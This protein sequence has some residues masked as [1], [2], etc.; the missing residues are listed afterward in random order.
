[1]A[2]AIKGRGLRK[3]LTH[4][5]SGALTLAFCA[6]AAVLVVVGSQGL[7]NRAAAAPEPEAAPVP[8]VAVQRVVEQDSFTVT[9][10]FLGQVEAQSEVDV[11][12]EFGGTL[13]RLL[14][15]EGD[16][17]TQGDVIAELDTELLVADQSRLEAER[18]ALQAQL[19][20]AES[21][22]QRAV[23]LAEDGFASQ[24]RVDQA[25]ASQ[26]E[27]A[28]RIDALDA[29]LLSI[30]ISLRKSVITAPVTGQVTARFVD[31]GSVLSA[32]QPV[33]GLT[34][35]GPAIVRVG[36]PLSLDPSDLDAPEI[37]IDGEH[38]RAT[39]IGT[40]PDIDPVTRTRTAL[41]ALQADIPAVFGQTIALS[42][43]IPQST[44]GLWLPLSALRAGEQGVW[45]VL[46]VQDD[47]V[48]VASVEVLHTS[49]ERAYVRGS[50]GAE[51]LLVADGAH[52]LVPGQQ[53]QPIL[54]EG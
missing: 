24:E 23:R 50:F 27:L 6:G 22:S 46:V 49:G 28:A 15:D 7:S 29:R 51:A 12:F 9:R 13:M 40:R 17:A 8:T 10:R 19:S 54:G 34:E 53:V 3:F 38:H 2:D 45:T 18:R 14:V 21:Q 11:A 1:M 25:Q 44:A 5:F 42:L 36:L 26:A 30:E 31:P 33:I 37:E 47:M 39:L 20:F 41:F 16:H 32:G 35:T 48:R 4:A 52:R 43:E